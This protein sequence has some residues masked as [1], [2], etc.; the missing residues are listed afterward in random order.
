MKTK[1]TLITIVIALTIPICMNA[2][3]NAAPIFLTI[4]PGSR[5]GAMGHAYVAQVDDA[6]AGWWNPG[7]MAFNRK[8]QIAAIHSNWLKGVFDD[9]YYEY[10]GWNQYIEDVG[11]VGANVTFMSF[12]SQQYMDE[13]GNAGGYF[14]SYEIAFAGT[15]AYQVAQNKGV[16]AT[17]KF[18]Y[19]SL[20]P[21]QGNTDTEKGQ[22]MTY[23]F[24]LGYKSIG[25]DFGQ[26]MV[27]PYNG[28]IAAYNGVSDLF[29]GGSVG[30]SEFSIPISKLD[31]GLNFQNIG[32][33]IT[34]M[35]QDQADPLPITWRMGYSYRL[36]EAEYSKLT[37]NADMS[38]I[39]ANDDPIYKRIFT[40]WVDDFNTKVDEE[41]N[42]IDDFASIND[43]VN[44]VEVTETIF[45]FGAE[46]VYL[47]LLSLRAGY[48]MDRAGEIEGLSFGAGVHKE[49]SKK[50][51]LGIDFAFQPG[52]GLTKYNQT[53][54]LK[55]EF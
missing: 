18:I 32:P 43:F 51:K 52:G 2:V 38:K 24:D 10:L 1:L 3:S 23:A 36:F 17:F 29:G 25:C 16:G 30:R 48:V 46:Y 54:S 37:F 4:E 40:A 35:D 5:S 22:G 7:A 11:N 41:G 31:F 47:N 33:N 34:Y 28:V 21:G 20:G 49:F 42:D 44:S 53:Y 19:S 39:L 45:G 13:Q 26:F 9:I 27:S 8:T 50:Y 55:L 14:S 15:Y 12:G 6:F